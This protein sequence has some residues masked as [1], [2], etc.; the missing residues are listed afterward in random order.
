MEKIKYSNNGKM[1]DVPINLHNLYEDLHGRQFETY[2]GFLLLNANCIDKEIKVE[3][4]NKDSW[5]LGT[6]WA[7]ELNTQ[8]GLF[9]F[10]EYMKSF[11]YNLKFI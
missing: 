5:C 11:G 4:Y 6:E 8:L 7:K 10:I 1:I 2:N 3:L 9:L